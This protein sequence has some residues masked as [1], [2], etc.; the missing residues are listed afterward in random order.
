MIEN[1][2]LPQ[3]LRLLDSI[4][5]AADE[6]QLNYSLDID[7]TNENVI[8]GEVLLKLKVRLSA[9]VPFPSNYFVKAD[10]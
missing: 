2:K 9:P 6:T 10:K 4:R 1:N 5:K 8:G 3:I 7:T